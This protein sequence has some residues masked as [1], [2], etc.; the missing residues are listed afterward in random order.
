MRTLTV[1]IGQ[2][3]DQ[4]MYLANGAATERAPW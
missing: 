3:L 2:Y 4:F 1:K